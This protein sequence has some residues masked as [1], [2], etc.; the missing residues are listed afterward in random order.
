MAPLALVTVDAGVGA[1]A[2]GSGN[3][4]CRLRNLA[5]PRLRGLLRSL[6]DNAT[7]V[8]ALG[9][10]VATP[11][12]VRANDRVSLPSAAGRW[13]GQLWR[14]L[15][16]FSKTVDNITVG[17]PLGALKRGKPVEQHGPGSGTAR[18]FKSV[19]KG[20]DGR[21]RIYRHGPA[22]STPR[23]PSVS[24]RRCPNVCP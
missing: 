11:K 13:C 12:V 8:H 4:G 6:R 19:S 14:Q 21:S 1:R 3:R 22:V 2:A 17:A 10:A 18:R 24:S 5:H 15:D 9:S 20:G 23:A 7:V 16:N